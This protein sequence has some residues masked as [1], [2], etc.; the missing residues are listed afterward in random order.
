[1]ESVVLTYSENGVLAWNSFSEPV[2]FASRSSDVI[3]SQ[4][5][6][7]KD[8]SLL[9]IMEPVVIRRALNK[10]HFPIITLASLSSLEPNHT[11]CLHALG[12]S[13]SNLLA[14]GPHLSFRNLSWATRINNLSK[15]SL[16]N[17]P[18]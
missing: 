4:R 7:G 15:N 16:K 1:M 18:K 14:R 9:A 2:G 12:Q 6:L 5:I 8:F 17:Y 3:V 11:M 10:Q 13:C